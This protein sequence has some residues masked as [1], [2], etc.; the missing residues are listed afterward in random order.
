MRKK[1]LLV[2]IPA[3]AVL[4]VLHPYFGHQAWAYVI[5]NFWPD[6]DNI[7][8]D[9]VFLPA[10]TWSAP[11]Q[12]Q[13]SE[14]NEVDTT[15]NSHPFRISSSP[16]F[17]FGANDGDNTMGFLG[18]AGLN[19]EYGL[20]Y[21]SALA[22]TA[23]W[24][25]FFSGRLDEC[26]V[27]LNPALAWQ[28]IP[29]SSNFF[30]STVLHETGHVRGLN[31]YNNYLSMQNSGT[32]KILR[33]ETLYMDDKV[34][35][36]R[37]ASFVSEADIVMYNKYHNGS[38]PLWMSM[39]PTTARVGDVITLNN[40]TVENRGSVPFGALR[41]GIYL[42]TNTIISS[43]DQL[44]NTGSFGSF[45]TFTFSTFN[46]GATVPALADCGT[47][48]L[49]GIIDDDG[50]YAERYEG[51]NSVPFNN[52]SPDP[53]ALT[54]L[55]E[56]DGQE[57]NDSLAGARA[58]GLPF[59][60]GSLTIDQDAEQDYYQMVL[61]QKATVTISAV[62]TH[63]SGDI[64]LDL[65]DPADTVLAASTSSGNSEQ[66]TREL[67]KGTY[68]VRVYGNSTGSCNRYSLAATSVPLFIR[69]TNPKGGQSWK[70]GTSKTIKWAS[71]GLT[72]NVRIQLSRDGG[73]TWKGL[74]RDVPNTGQQVWTVH[75]PTTTQARIRV[76]SENNL[77]VRDISN[78][79]FAIIR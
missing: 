71:S 63:S 41:F 45:G 4:P 46:W 68:Y 73:A 40:I 34:A 53:Q 50:A 32:D 6:G 56:R 23:C 54:L 47:Y 61:A 28:L 33:G 62:F 7:V 19:S 3:L 74:Y 79:D 37:N 64:D 18:E 26:D 31:H 39:S 35:V 5:D 69:V 36:R 60:A 29:D 17:S 66:I 16:Q 57:P 42:S 10:D 2:L 1:F 76:L 24:T 25:G 77:R 9:D 52:G 21:A 30:Q 65:R 20:S 67:V 78:T 51:N 22:W 8:M 15:D 70:I 72:G 55:L 12:Y 48:Y 11:A 14:W 75:G 49:G 44:L 27:M 43:F 38:V 13:L 59:N 58:I